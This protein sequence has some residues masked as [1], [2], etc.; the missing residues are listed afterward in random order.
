MIEVIT[1]FKKFRLFKV[2]KTKRIKKGVF[3]TGGRI[4]LKRK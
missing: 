2:Q 4:G 1:K 3:Y